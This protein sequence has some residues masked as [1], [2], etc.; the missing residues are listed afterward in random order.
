MIIIRLPIFSR[1]VFLNGLWQ[2]STGED[3]SQVIYYLVTAQ[4]PYTIE[5]YL[6]TWGGALAERI[7]ILPYE[8]LAQRKE[9]SLGTY[10]FSDIDRL[11]PP[12]VDM[13]TQVWEQL[14]KYKEM[15]PLYNHPRDSLRRHSLLEILH[16]SGWN[17]FKAYR[18]SEVGH[19]LRY[20]V[21]IRHA[22]SHS[23]NLTGLLKN[24][25]E[26][27]QSLSKFIR[28]NRRL[29]N[30]LVVEFCDTVDMNGLYR[31]YGAFIVGDQIIPRHLIFS[32]HWVV[33]F[34]GILNAKLQREEK[35][36]LDSNPH[37]QEL[38]AIFRAARIDYGRIDYALYEDS[39][40]IWEIN[41]NPVVMMIPE[42]YQPG[43]LPAQE[44]FAPRIQY[45]FE[46]IDCPLDPVHSFPISIDPKTIKWLKSTD[47]AR[48]RLK[49]Y[50]D[51]VALAKKLVP[52]PLQSHLQAL[53]NVFFHR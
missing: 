13:V 40:Q 26:L 4:H 36:Y 18:A 29:S 35:D 44:Q 37:E 27:D 11:T 41:T 6:N 53:K 8:E 48:K 45:A 43:H 33:K 24:R 19:I 21:F 17:R 30:Y 39:L 10:I 34:P 23:A 16:D 28:E 22:D 32:R 51:L 52:A 20:P 25:K 42:Q 31:K 38:R 1:P 50:R 3:Q 9:L 12:Q 47:K 2:D 7:Q 49:Y 5:P 46:A 14:N 15:M